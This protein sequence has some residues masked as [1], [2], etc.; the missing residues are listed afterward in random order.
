VVRK[1]ARSRALAPLGRR[2]PRVQQATG[3][4]VEGGERVEQVELLEHEADAPRAQRRQLVV[5]RLGDIDALVA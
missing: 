5:G 1:V 3:N 4:V 2:Q